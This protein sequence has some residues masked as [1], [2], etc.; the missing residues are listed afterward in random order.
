MH[1]D[2]W[3]GQR[4]IP[5]VTLG[6]TENSNDI[7]EY[8]STIK[9]APEAILKGISVNIAGKHGTVICN[10]PVEEPLGIEK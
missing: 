8:I 1:N 6:Y 5:H 10:E 4:F 9:S 7:K 2:K 3:G